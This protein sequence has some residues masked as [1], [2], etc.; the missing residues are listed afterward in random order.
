MTFAPPGVIV[1]DGQAARVFTP[2]PALGCN[3]TASYP[4]IVGQP[5]TFEVGDQS[6][7]TWRIGRRANG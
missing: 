3:D 1:V 2:E 6:A 5:P 7:D 4:A